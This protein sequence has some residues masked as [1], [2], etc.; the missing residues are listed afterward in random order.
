MDLETLR[1]KYGSLAPALTERSRRLW[2]ATEARALWHGGIAMV[3]RATG[4]SRSTIV[5]GI[6]ETKAEPNRPCPLPFE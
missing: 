6:Q 3:E 1:A 5:R 2:V 4:I